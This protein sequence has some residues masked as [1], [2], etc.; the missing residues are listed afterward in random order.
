MFLIIGT[1]FVQ[2]IGTAF[3]QTQLYLVIINHIIKQIANK[4]DWA[5]D[6]EIELRDVSRF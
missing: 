6:F 1:A 4:T 5:A 2:T 3:V